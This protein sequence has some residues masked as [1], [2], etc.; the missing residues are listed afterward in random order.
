[1]Q[2]VVVVIQPRKVQKLPV[3]PLSAH[4]LEVLVGHVDSV[5]TDAVLELV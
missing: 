4:Y 2:K 3:L 1:M 5:L